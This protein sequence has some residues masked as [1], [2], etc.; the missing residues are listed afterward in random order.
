MNRATLCGIG[1]QVMRGSRLGQ[2]VG[3]AVFDGVDF[4]GWNDVGC[5]RFPGRQT[6]IPG[7]CHAEVL[8]SI[9]PIRETRPDASEYLSMTVSIH[10][11]VTRLRTY[12]SAFPTAAAI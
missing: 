1:S 8:R 11:V 10:F 3:Q 2:G 7:H 12:F 4:P 5:A 9:W 6:A